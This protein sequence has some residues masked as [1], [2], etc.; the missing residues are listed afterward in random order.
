MARGEADRILVPYAG[1]NAGPRGCLSRSPGKNLTNNVTRS[2]TLLKPEWIATLSLQPTA[3]FTPIPAPYIY[4][5]RPLPPSHQLH[6]FSP[7]SS[8]PHLHRV[9]NVFLLLR[10]VRFHKF[11]QYHPWPG[12]GS[13]CQRVGGIVG[14][15]P[16]H[17]SYSLQ[18][19][20]RAHKNQTRATMASALQT[21]SG[22]PLR[23]S[24]P[25]IHLPT[26]E[27]PFDTYAPLLSPPAATPEQLATPCPPF[28][29]L[30]LAG[31]PATPSP[32]GIQPV[33]LSTP[34]APVWQP[35]SREIERFHFCPYT[36]DGRVC[37][38]VSWG[39]SGN[40]AV[41]RHMK[42]MHFK[43]GS[44]A[45]AWKCPNLK[46]GRKGRPFGRKD[47]LVNHRRRTCD[48]QH[49][50]ENPDYFPLPDVEEGNE[51]E[52]KRWI[53]AGRE[54]RNLIRKKLRADTP[55]SGDLLKPTH[56]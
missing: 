56:L 40:K 47:S 51:I 39:C 42:R 41:E 43:L 9:Q 54:Q 30:P 13:C 18:G 17:I 24:P 11:P 20:T 55:W 12:R 28:L 44:N 50:Q 19:L 16:I 49:L 52:V 29:N 23:I 53:T 35:T 31:P 27:H 14:D 5:S 7:L 33:S 32:T 36:K 15:L 48:S 6:T 4:L 25:L 38:F 3:T 46:C 1:V 8:P 10:N 2:S 45:K 37:G 22:I 34:P 21:L 26:P